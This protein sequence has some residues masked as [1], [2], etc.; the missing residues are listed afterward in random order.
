MLLWPSNISFVSANIHI[1]FH[2]C[3]K[4]QG[5]YI[6]I[7]YIL[8]LHKPYIGINSIILYANSMLWRI[9]HNFR[10]QK[11]IFKGE[12][13]EIILYFEMF[14]AHSKLFYINY[15]FCLF[16]WGYL[17]LQ[18]FICKLENYYKKGCKRRKFTLFCI[19]RLNSRVYNAQKYF[20]FVK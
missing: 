15:K 18:F 8:Q 4:G 19:I 10:G 9:K 2:M 16:N 12:K 7:F 17:S 14:L 5:T 11:V 13:C 3:L 6:K 1:Y 20:L